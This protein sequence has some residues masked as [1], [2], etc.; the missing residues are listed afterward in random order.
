MNRKPYCFDN[1]FHEVALRRRG[2]S[3]PDPPIMTWLDV[4]DQSDSHHLHTLSRHVD[5][6][7]LYIVQRGQG[8]HVIEDKPYAMS[9]GDVYVM[10]LDT[11]HYYIQCRN[12]VVQGLYFT[13]NLFDA[14]TLDAFAAIPGI[15][16]LIPGL[17]AEPIKPNPAGR[18]LH[19]TPDAYEQVADQLMKLNAEWEANRPGCGL[20][21]RSLLICLLIHLTRF[22]A[23]AHVRPPAVKATAHTAAISAAIRDMEEHYAEDLRIEQVAASVFLSRHQFTKVFSEAVGQTPRA[24]LRHIRIERAKALLGLTRL[25]MNIVADQSGF[26]EAAYFARAFRAAT[27]MTP[28]EYRRCSWAENGRNV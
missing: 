1:T 20:M 17:M 14:A 11:A 28:T 24:Y 22:Q 8:T 13:P 19:M 3:H 10:G 5:F 25:S 6:F 7:A 21:L 9:R 16:S 27:G 18:W 12:L 2:T 26:G 23:E 15:S 4:I